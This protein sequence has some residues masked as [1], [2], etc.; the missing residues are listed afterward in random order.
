MKYIV[1]STKILHHF[2]HKVFLIVFVLAVFLGT[3]YSVLTPVF[4]EIDCLNANP[5]GFSASDA[6]YCSNQLTNLIN[7]YLPA[8]QTN[9]KTLAG[10]QSQLNDINARITALSNQIQILSSD[11]TKREED[12]AFA[13]EIFN[14][15]A[16]DQYTF[17][18]LYD[19]ITPFLSSSDATQA[20]REISFRQRAADSDRKTMDQYAQDLLNLKN[21][22]DAL[23]KTKDSLAVSQKQVAERTSF[24]AAEV[25]KV[26]TYLATLSA[27][28]QAF[29][30]AKLESLGISRSAYNLHGGCSSDI[31]KSPNFSLAI[32]FFT[33]GVPNRIGLNQYGAKGRA[34]VGQG[35]DQILRAYYSFDSYQNVDPGTTIRVNDGNGINTGNVIWSG[36]L[37]DYVRRIYEVP[38]DWP[39]EAL[40][41]QAVAARS[42]VLAATNNGA[43]SICANEYCQVFKTDPK[44]G[45]WDSAVTGTEDGGRGIV[46]IQGGQPIKAWFSAV[47]GGYAYGSGDIGW[48][49]TPWTKRMVDTPSG[50]AGSFS[51]LQNNAYDK[52]AQWFYCDWGGRSAYNGT[53]WLKPEEVADIVNVI[54][55]ARR[56]SSTKPHLYQTDKPNPEGT[57]TWD[58]GRVKQELGASAINS[59]SNISV[60]ADFGS[61]LTTSVNI[62]G[63]SF[64][65]KEFKD[66]FNL[67]APSNI[68]IVGPLFNVETKSF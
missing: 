9:K 31:N 54:L 10:L 68:Q 22:K 18:R 2:V 26:D 14:Q 47:H 3:A 39:I 64:G 7:Q 29:L 43:N 34:D 32:G 61:G 45:G 57:D 23:Q 21:D 24:L 13:R 48:S 8:Q 12:M 5:S 19:P 51:D 20:F 36:S 67:R 4:A 17:L 42:Y 41:A 60:S 44:V 35:Y 16:K 49:S 37:E 27:K 46:M 52:S 15:K 62:D 6:E 1:R 30:A 66:Y 58:A 65:A 11:I 55:L 38:G 25:A 50:S 53:G 40:K 59:V 28:Q 56:D 33:F 63:Q